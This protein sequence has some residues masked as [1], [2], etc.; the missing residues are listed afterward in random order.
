MLQASVQV[1]S[2]TAWNYIRLWGGVWGARGA[3]PSVDTKNLLSSAGICGFVLNVNICKS[4][5][6]ESKCSYTTLKLIQFYCLGF[7]FSV[8]YMNICVT[9]GV[10][11]H[12][13]KS[14][15]IDSKCSYTQTH[16]VLLIVWVLLSW[17]VTWTFVWLVVYTDSSPEQRRWRKLWQSVGWTRDKLCWSSGKKI[18][19]VCTCSFVAQLV[20]PDF[21]L[22]SLHC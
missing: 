8:C 13:C 14:T 4:T 1:S 5:S 19:N 18:P 10:Y 9:C 11:T 17:S 3:D 15:S 12:L 21:C 6:V 20:C 2:N 7:A 22:Y 16:S